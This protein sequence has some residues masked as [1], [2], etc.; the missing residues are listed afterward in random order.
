MEASQGKGGRLMLLPRLPSRVGQPPDGLLSRQH[1]QPLRGRPRRRSLGNL[2]FGNPKRQLAWIRGPSS[3]K[4]SAGGRIQLVQ[5]IP[6]CRSSGDPPSSRGKSDSRFA[7]PGR[8][9]PQGPKE[10][11]G[12]TRQAQRQAFQGPTRSGRAGCPHVLL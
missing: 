9:Y 6:A 10:Q 3:H 12:S 4:L 11:F 8:D 7:C 2:W 5:W 1:R